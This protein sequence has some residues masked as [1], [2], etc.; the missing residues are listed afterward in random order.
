MYALV[1]AQNEHNFILLLVWCVIFL[2]LTGCCKWNAIPDINWSDCFQ[3]YKQ[4]GHIGCAICGNSWIYIYLYQF[5]FKLLSF[6]FFLTFSAIYAYENSCF[7]SFVGLR[8]NESNFLFR[9]KS[10][11]FNDLLRIKFEPL[12]TNI[13]RWTACENKYKKNERKSRNQ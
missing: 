7:F 5:H 12:H 8:I 11:G 10:G 9:Y 13:S 4:R 3:E 2:S 1:N 6:V